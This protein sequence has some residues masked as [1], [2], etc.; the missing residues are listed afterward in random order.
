MRIPAM[1]YLQTTLLVSAMLSIAPGAV[2]AQSNQTIQDRAERQQDAYDKQHHNTAK[3]VG[4]TAAGGALIG[5]LAG[6][7]KG[8]LIGGAAGG[9]AGYVGDKVRKH[10]GTKK[11]ARQMRERRTYRH[12]TE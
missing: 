8:A 6:G 3:T 10:Y 9:G 1:K 11:R 12:H 4:G 2:L 5:G 7:G